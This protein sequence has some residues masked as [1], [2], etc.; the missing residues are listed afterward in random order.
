MKNKLNMEA[1]DSVT[2]QGGGDVNHG[3]YSFA[4]RLGGNQL[5]TLSRSDEADRKALA[6]EPDAAPDMSLKEQFDLRPFRSV[7]IW[8]A[9]IIEGIGETFLCGV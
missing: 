5:F 2:G 4:G 7:G 6:E 8:K 9:A 3:S 1:G